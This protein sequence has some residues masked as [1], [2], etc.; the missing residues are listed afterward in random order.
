MA[1]RGPR[2][3]KE[4]FARRGQ[5]L[6]DRVVRPKLRPEDDFKFVAIDIETGEYEI[7][8][9]DHTAVMRLWDRLPDP[10]PWLMQVGQRGAHRLGARSDPGRTG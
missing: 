10:Q 7:D 8:A 6:Y 1:D 2:Y 9:D 4:E 3:S 5:E